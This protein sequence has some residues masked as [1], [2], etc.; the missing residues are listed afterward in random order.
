MRAG[1]DIDGVIYRW[2]DEARRLL[3]NEFGYSLLPSTHWD[4]IKSEIPPHAWD[5][6]WTGGVERGLFR[7]GALFTGAREAL[8]LLWDSAVTIA[9]ITTTPVN[10]R[11][12]RTLWL[13]SSQLPHDELHFMSKKHHVQCDFYVEDNVDNANLLLTTGRP[14]YLVDRLYNQ[15][16]FGAFIRV[17][18][19]LHAVQDALR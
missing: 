11:A 5:W 18:S 15:G 7:C 12:D 17:P 1:I 10:A 8:E 3:A 19:L 16:A 9:L 14:V 6:L 2:E 4:S 13:A